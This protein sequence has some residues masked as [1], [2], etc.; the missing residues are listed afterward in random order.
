MIIQF[1]LNISSEEKYL[2]KNW[3]KNN[4]TYQCQIVRINGVDYNFIVILKEDEIVSI[5][6]IK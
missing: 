6:V 1:S 5:R 3:L 4:K 2:I